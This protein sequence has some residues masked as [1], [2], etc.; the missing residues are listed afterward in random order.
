[1]P[2]LIILLYSQPVVEKHPDPIPSLPELYSFTN[3]FKPVLGVGLELIQNLTWSVAK[4]E[5]PENVLDKKR[6]LVPED[7][8]LI[9]QLSKV[10][11][12]LLFF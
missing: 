7:K 12:I 6:S 3:D 5:L 11:V 10:L 4:E 8:R 9:E 1:M 2:T